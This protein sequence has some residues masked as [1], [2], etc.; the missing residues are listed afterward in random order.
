MENLDAIVQVFYPGEEGGT[1]V[2][3]VLFGDYNPSG[4]LPVTVPVSTEQLPAF[5]DYDMSN[6]TYRYMKEK[7]LFPFGHGLSYTTFR[8][9]KAKLNR[10]VI[11]EGESVK[12]SVDVTNTGKVA[13]DE[14][15]QLYTRDQRASVPV[16]HHS[17][18]GFCRVS[19]KPRQTKRVEFELASSAFALVDNDGRR[20]LEPGDFTIF[21]GGGQPGFSPTVELALRA[22]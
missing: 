15:V 9:S 19:L 8:Y 5:E 22:R 14:V 21:L 4:R 18:R 16:S 20:V 1:A 10:K 13:G 17:L 7:P 11:A 12:V 3:D 2:A 6:R